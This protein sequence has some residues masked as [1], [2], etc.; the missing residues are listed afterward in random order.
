MVCLVSLYSC[1]V[2]ATCSNCQI[3]R[4]FK[5]GVQGQISYAQLQLRSWFFGEARGGKVNA[6]NATP[7]TLE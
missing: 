3:L 2:L 4:E 7:G 5:K 6:A 1:H